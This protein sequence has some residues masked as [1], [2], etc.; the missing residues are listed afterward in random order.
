M[1]NFDH[2]VVFKKSNKTNL[3]SLKGEK[4]MILLSKLWGRH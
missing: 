3:L 1:E 4:A 2:I